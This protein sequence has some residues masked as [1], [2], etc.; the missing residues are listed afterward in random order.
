ML[1]LTTI[2]LVFSPALFAII[3]FASAGAFGKQFTFYTGLISSLISLGTAIILGTQ[4]N[5]E[6]AFFT[7]HIFV[8]P[9]IM[10]GV[11]FSFGLDGLSYILLLLT[12]FIFPLCFLSI[13]DNVKKNP[14]IF[15]ALL[16]LLQTCIFGLF[17]ASDLA[18]F[19]VFFEA[20]L[21]PMY[22]LIGKWGGAD[23]IYA[24][25]KFF[26][27]TVVGSLLMLVAIAYIY[28]TVGSLSYA[29]VLAHD[30]SDTEQKLL[31]L[32]FFAGFAVKIPMFP[33]HTWL[34]V[35][36]VEAPTS[37]SVLLAA[38]L[39][40]TAGYGFLRFS[41]PLFPDA[42]FYFSDAVIYLSVIAIIYASLVAFAQTDIKRLIAYSSVAHMGYVTMAIF[43]FREE[44]IQG[45]I[46]QMISH[47]FVSAGLFFGVGV[48]YDRYHTRD[49]A[50]YGGLAKIM[51][52]FALAFMVFTMANAGLPG[53]SGF[54]GEFL[55][56][57]SI[58]QKSGTL[59]FIVAIAV[60]LSAAYSLKLYRKI[61]FEETDMNK[62]RNA[63]DL[64]LRETIILY[65]PALAV[66]FF[67]FYAE[68]ILNLTETVTKQ[69][70]K[71][72]QDFEIS[73]KNKT[74]ELSAD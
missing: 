50:F 25:M 61:N 4:L 38:I 42:S 13:K 59:A 53:T 35:A 36:H 54:I 18:L 6:Q 63:V 52:S 71:N 49:I 66:I 10:K 72:Y 1:E 30:F 27:F 47:G 67:G 60:I 8:F 5:V 43:T 74:V 45:A 68:P 3:L 31:W 19:Y 15:T 2:S 48:L 64:N 73:P 44:G 55:A 40:K 22:I 51:P 14:E 58:M 12:A 17:L 70:V 32:A 16:L 9:W 39:L 20:S 24:A 56:I 26:L 29:D 62:F 34:P 7:D 28:G 57:F 46:F 37:G 21:I 33:F 23:R 65:T 69:I 41:L 11:S